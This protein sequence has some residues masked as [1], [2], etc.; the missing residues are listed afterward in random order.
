MPLRKHDSI[1]LIMMVSVLLYTQPDIYK[2]QARYIRGFEPKPF[3]VEHRALPFNR[4]IEPAGA[5]VFG[6]PGRKPCAG[7]CF[8]PDANGWL[9]RSLNWSFFGSH[10]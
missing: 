8:S 10:R 1:L 5:N 7:C 3:T 2:E 6:N 9:L 4:W